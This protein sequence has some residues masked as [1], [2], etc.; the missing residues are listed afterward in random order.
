MRICPACEKEKDF[1]G[2]YCSDECLEKACLFFKKFSIP[3]TIGNFQEFGVMSV[4]E[5]EYDGQKP[6]GKVYG[7]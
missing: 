4:L 2:K 5:K 7:N 6:R 1:F 3:L